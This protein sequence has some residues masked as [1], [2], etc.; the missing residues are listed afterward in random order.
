MLHEFDIFPC[1]LKRKFEFHFDFLISLYFKTF[2]TNSVE[3]KM[4]F[5]SLNSV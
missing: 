4:V 3:V 5:L 1:D 2:I